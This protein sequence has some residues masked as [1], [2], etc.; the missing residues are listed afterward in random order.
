[1][2]MVA[3]RSSG[4]VNEIQSQAKYTNKADMGVFLDGIVLRAL[5]RNSFEMFLLKELCGEGFVF[6][7][8][9]ATNKYITYYFL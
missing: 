1:M 8:L 7:F 5:T 2:N 3:K 4:K 9:V 6:L